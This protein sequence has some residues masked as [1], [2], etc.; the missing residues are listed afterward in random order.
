[1]SD[2]SKDVGF[3]DEVAGQGF[4]NLSGDAYS[5]PF[6][7][8]LQSNSK[9]V[10]SEL[11]GAK[12]GVF[13]DAAR[14]EVLGN[15][16]KVIP[17]DFEILWLEWEENMGGL[18]GK[19]LPHSI[20][21]SGDKF[22]RKNP[23][24]GRELTDS[25]CYYV[26]LAGREDEGVCILSLPVSAIKFLKAWNTMNNRTKLP[27]GKPA[28]FYGCIWEIG[29]TIK[30]KNDNGQVWYNIGD[31]KGPAIKNLGFINKDVFLDAVKPGIESAKT[32]MLSYQQISL[33]PA[34]VRQALPESPKNDDSAF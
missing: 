18:K 4:G 32:V 9:E 7:K 29:P 26:L 5:T 17:L 30:E 15:T 12:P 27:T 33:V 14:N 8:L 3:L 28:P 10:T 11:P 22:N 25:W 24:T 31:D 23:A 21:S 13:Y 34:P 16:I 6:I 20:P 19:Y 2:E 1:M